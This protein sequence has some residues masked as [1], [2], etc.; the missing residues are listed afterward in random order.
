[1]L[2]LI[3]NVAHRAET[4]LRCLTRLGGSVAVL[5]NAWTMP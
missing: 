1:L 5:L 2:V 3:Q 4:T